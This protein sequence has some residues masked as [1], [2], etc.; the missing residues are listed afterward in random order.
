M[1]SQ[2]PGNVEGRPVGRVRP[3]GKF[4]R[5]GAD[6]WY[7]K[8]FSYGPFAPNEDGDY[9]PER[10][11]WRDDLAQMR[12]LGAN[13]VRLYHAPPLHFLDDAIEA[14]LRVFVD[15]PWEKHRCF[16]EDWRSQEDAR[17]RVRQTA[18]TLGK[19]PGLFAI[20]VVNEF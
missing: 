9:L 12:S 17:K 1:S 6:K 10:A 14:G 2:Q 8:G 7:L 5:L 4:F 19:H 3:S 20:S 15:V 16:L 13:T 18:N 11:S